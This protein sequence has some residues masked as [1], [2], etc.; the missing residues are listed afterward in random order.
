MTDEGIRIIC[1]TV[2]RLAFLG[3]SMWFLVKNKKIILNIL[4][5]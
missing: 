5:I 4:F 2:M 1:D 3:F